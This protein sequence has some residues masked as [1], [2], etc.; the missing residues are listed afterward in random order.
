MIYGSIPA[1]YLMSKSAIEQKGMHPVAMLSKQF[2]KDTFGYFDQVDCRLK[3]V[4]PEMFGNSDRS[5]KP[6]ESGKKPA[7]VVA[8]ASRSS[9]TKKVIN[10]VKQQSNTRC[11]KAKSQLLMLFAL[12]KTWS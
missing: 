7:T 8:S 11:L 4:F 9:G 12:L 2:L 10:K 5:S 1:K 6:A 3:Q